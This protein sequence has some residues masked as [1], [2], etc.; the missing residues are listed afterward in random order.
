MPSITSDMSGFSPLPSLCL[1]DRM[2]PIDH[3][4][5][6]LL[7]VFQSVP[8]VVI[9]CGNILVLLDSPAPWNI[10]HRDFFSLIHVQCASLRDLQDSEHLGR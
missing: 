7:D 3:Q 8:L 1:C 2:L 10:C 9:A 6:A 5:L 4:S